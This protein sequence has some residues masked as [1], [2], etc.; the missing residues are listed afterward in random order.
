MVGCHGKHQL[1]RFC[2]PVSHNSEHSVH[3][4]QHSN[5]GYYQSDAI[6]GLQHLLEWDSA[7]LLRY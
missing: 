6:A 7:N 1:Q 5:R 2:D 3:E 4:Q